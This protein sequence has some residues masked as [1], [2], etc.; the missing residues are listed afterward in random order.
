M[1]W[2]PNV[3]KGEPEINTRKVQPENSKLSDLDDDTRSM[4]E[5][6]MFDQRQKEMGKPTSEEQQKLDILEKWVI[7]LAD[8]GPNHTHTHTLSLSLTHSLTHSLTLTTTCFC[9][10]Q[11]QKGQ[12]RHGLFKRE[13]DVTQLQNPSLF[14][15]CIPLP[16]TSLDTLCQTPAACSVNKHSKKADGETTATT[17]VS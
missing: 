15:I 1:E 4:V 2:W 13:D 16:P 14:S 5:K 10:V 8:L 17:G 7:V 9:C 3:V 11:D 6:M 12:P